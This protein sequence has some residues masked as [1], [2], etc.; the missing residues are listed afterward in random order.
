[1]LLFVVL[2]LLD[3]RGLVEIGLFVLLVL[4]G[5]EEQVQKVPECHHPNPLIAQEHSLQQRFGS[6]L[7]FL[8]ENGMCQEW[9][10]VF[11]IL[12]QQGKQPVF[13]PNLAQKH[14]N[15]DHSMDQNTD[16]T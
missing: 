12:F 16:Q 8:F 3:W 11:R 9:H 6:V 14:Y 4:L 1:M 13:I 15:M 5:Q 10:H 2:V 7:F